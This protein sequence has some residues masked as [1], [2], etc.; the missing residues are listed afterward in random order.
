MNELNERTE[1]FMNEFIHVINS[2]LVL[3]EKVSAIFLW[4]S[5]LNVLS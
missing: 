1:I 4:L 2:R 3:F 5:F